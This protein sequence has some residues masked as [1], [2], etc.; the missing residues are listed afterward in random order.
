MVLPYIYPRVYVGSIGRSVPASID[1]F[2]QNFYSRILHVVLCMISRRVKESKF[3]RTLESVRIARPSPLSRFGGSS[4]WK[5]DRKV[6][7]SGPRYWRR[8][9]E[10]PS[11]PFACELDCKCY[12][13]NAA[14]SSEARGQRRAS[15][16]FY[17]SIASVYI[18]YNI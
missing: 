3:D 10:V 6:S 9:S 11:R 12:P 14:C 16:Y 13:G 15:F 1:L 7:G 18:S 17:D 4:E 2:E 8:G 5:L